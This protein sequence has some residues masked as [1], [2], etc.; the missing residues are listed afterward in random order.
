VNP[1]SLC[2]VSFDG[3]S[4]FDSMFPWLLDVELAGKSVEKS[5]PLNIFIS[6]PASAI[7]T[8]TD[9]EKA[10]ILQRIKD[11]EEKVRAATKDAE[12]KRKQLQ[13]EGK[14]RAIE[15]VDAAAL[16]LRREI[17]TRI[18]EA[19][20]RIESRKKALLDEGARKAD[21]LTSSARQRA[22]KAREFV[23]SE[24]ERAADA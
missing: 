22:G 7:W 2:N 12:D 3:I 17:D 20:A 16:A 1:S 8:V 4:C 18:A 19:K 5:D 11:A 23:L 9:L 21:A 14:R 24:F 15:D 6:K 13:A 10:D